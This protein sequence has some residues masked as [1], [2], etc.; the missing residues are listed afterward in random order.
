M[1]NSTGHSGYAPEATDRFGAQQTVRGENELED[2]IAYLQGLL[3][4]EKLLRAIVRKELLSIKKN[5]EIIV[6]L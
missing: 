4:D 6:E 2:R 1:K 5:M 3:A